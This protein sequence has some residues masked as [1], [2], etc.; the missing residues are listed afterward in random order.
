MFKFN[1]GLYKK[2]FP[3][4]AQTGKKKNMLA[5]DQFNR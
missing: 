2:M 5:F 4:H 3:R 1:Q